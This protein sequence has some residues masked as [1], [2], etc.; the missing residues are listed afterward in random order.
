VSRGRT[1]QGRRRDGTGP[2]GFSPRGELGALRAGP[3][4]RRGRIT[5]VASG[6]ALAAGSPA[7]RF[8]AFEAGMA[9]AADPEHVVAPQRERKDRHEQAHHEGSWLEDERST[10]RPPQ[11]NRGTARRVCRR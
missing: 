7:T 11:L 8:A 5:V 9:S 2:P 10:P 6:A 1:A 4:V 3:A